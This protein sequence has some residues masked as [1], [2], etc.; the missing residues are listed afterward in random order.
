MD[1]LLHLAS[2][3][4][5]NICEYCCI[6]YIACYFLFDYFT[7]YREEAVSQYNLYFK[8]TRPTRSDAT[9]ELIVLQLPEHLPINH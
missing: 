9:V 8:S 2:G 4:Q 5:V 1:L 6:V 7:A 3:F